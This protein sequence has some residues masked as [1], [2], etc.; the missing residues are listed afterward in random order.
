MLT[1]LVT[2]VYVQLWPYFFCIDCK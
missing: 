2:L 1:M